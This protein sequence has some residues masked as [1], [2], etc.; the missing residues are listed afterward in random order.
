MK[1]FIA[2][3]F[4]LLI[5]YSSSSM[6]QLVKCSYD[7]NPFTD[8]V[9]LAGS[10]S[11]GED[12]PIGSVIY[13]GSYS[14]DQYGI[15]ML[16][17]A[18]AWNTSLPEIIA[19]PTVRMVSNPYPVVPGI[20]GTG[21]D[22]RLVYKTNIPGVGVAIDWNL[23]AEY[24]VPHV[25]GVNNGG[26]RSSGHK[27][28][29]YLIKIDNISPGLLNGNILPTLQAYIRSP[30]PMPGVEFSGFPTIY[31]D[32]K[33][34][35]Q[36]QIVTSTCDIIT[37]N[38]SVELGKYT[39]NDFS[40]VNSYT[41]WKS[42]AIEL[43]GCTVFSP[44]YYSLDVTRYVNWVRGE[45][46]IRVGETDTKNRIT[47]SLSSV[48]GNI[49]PVNGIMSLES[50]RNTAKGIGIQIGLEKNGVI[51][52]I[53]LSETQ[54]IDLPNAVNR[55]KVPLFARYIQTDTV[56]TGGQANGALIYTINYH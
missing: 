50:G 9:T 41:P 12:V 28:Y 22:H 7:L 26:T 24:Y 4:L 29:F 13:Q 38:F 35:G 14:P 53:S 3:L 6:A 31:Y 40:G 21:I 10:I 46:T 36:I 44:G 20:T 25:I 33:F 45:G 2:C 39:S 47:M 27:I 18:S 16:C 56:I 17:R 55:V 37:P 8:T 19:Y 1:V 51:S 42:A 5:N 23:G 32:L 43:Q 34:S 48:N 49:S 11:V 30:V 52:P 54:E 15:S